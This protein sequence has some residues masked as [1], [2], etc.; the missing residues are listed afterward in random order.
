M[1]LTMAERKTVT[2][3]LAEQYRR[4]PKKKKGWLLAQFVEATGYNQ[5]YASRLLRNY[6]RRQEVAPGV[7]VEATGRGRRGNPRP[8]RYGGDADNEDAAYTPGVRVRGGRELSP[9]ERVRLEGRFQCFLE[10][11]AAAVVQMPDTETSPK[12]VADFIRKAYHQNGRKKGLDPGRE[13]VVFF[14]IAL[15]GL[16]FFFLFP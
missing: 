8:R 6:G 5:V 15:K 13:S 1:R 11:D 9:M 3:A 12:S 16:D 4:S 2:K 7:V 10:G 14:L